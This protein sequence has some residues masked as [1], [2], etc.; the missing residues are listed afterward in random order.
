[1]RVDEGGVVTGDIVEQDLPGIGRCFTLTDAGNSRVMVVIHHTGRRDVYVLPPGQP[2][3]EPAATV[4][5]TD[6]QARRLG[7]ILSGAYFKPAVVARVEAVIGGLLIDWATVR[8]ESP[9]AG[10]SIADLEIRRRTRMTVA[11]IIHPD[12]TSVIAPEPHETIRADDQLVVV[13]RPEDLPRFLQ[14]AIG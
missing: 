11:A 7:S 12:G 10:H 9:A 4:T 14:L 1:V 8:P 13:G 3:D 2:D 5:L 6:D